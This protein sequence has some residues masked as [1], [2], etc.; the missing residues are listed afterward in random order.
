LCTLTDMT[1]YHQFPEAQATDFVDFRGPGGI[2]ASHTLGPDQRYRRRGVAT[3]N[4]LGMNPSL[5]NDLLRFTR[6]GMP[7]PVRL[8]VALPGSGSTTAPGRDADDADP[9]ITASPG[10]SDRR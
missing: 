5:E 9:S 2:M 6:R 1:W 8:S 3:V 7:L 10:W 4:F